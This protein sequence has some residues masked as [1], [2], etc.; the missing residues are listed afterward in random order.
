MKFKMINRIKL[1]VF[2][3]CLGLYSCSQESDE[4]QYCTHRLHSSPR[5]SLVSNT[6]LDSIRVLFDRNQIDFNAYQFF[7]YEHDTYG[8]YHVRCYQFNQQLKLFSE[9]LIF[10]FNKNKNFYFLSGNLI[11]TT[12]LDT[13]PTRSTNKIAGLFLEMLSKDSFNSGDKAI[14]NGCFD[15]E[16]GYYNLNAGTG[17]ITPDFAKAWWVKPAGTDYPYAYV[18]DV[19]GAIILYDNG[20]RY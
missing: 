20:I 12:G 19:R 17:V 16:F 3:L 1:V 14:I 4:T 11:T 9:D 2:I 6:D 13:I 10:H 7:K 18:D 15:L 5:M 8:S